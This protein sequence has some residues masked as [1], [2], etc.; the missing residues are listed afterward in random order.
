VHDEREEE[1]PL[2]EPVGSGRHLRRME[3]AGLKSKGGFPFPWKEKPP[4]ERSDA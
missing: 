1:G 4:F 2:E 3:A